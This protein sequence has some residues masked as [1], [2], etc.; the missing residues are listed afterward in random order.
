MESVKYSIDENNC[1]VVENYNWAKPFADFFPGIAGKFGVP[2]WIYFVNRGQGICSMG[3]N[4]KD[5]AI[6]EFI[7]FNRALATVEEQGFRTFIKENG[8]LYEPF[9]KTRDNTNQKLTMSSSELYLDEVNNSL[10][11]EVKVKY[12]PLVGSR[13]PA[14]L[15]TLVIKNISNK[16]KNLCIADGLAKIICK[17]MDRA[18]LQVTARHIEGMIE[19]D[20]IEDM[21]LYKLKQAAT[22]VEKI[23]TI[24]GGNFYFSFLKDTLLTKNIIYDPDV[25]FAERSMY[26]TPWNFIDKSSEELF[27][28]NQINYYRIHIVHFV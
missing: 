1:F 19:L 16:T 20:F 7:S 8:I 23:E 13:T 5:H 2:M 9:L 28:I 24:A 21:P 25:I 22:D 11:L 12:F 4:T 17:G 26:K 18:A 10:G 14:L 15:R 6:L 3:V 27:K